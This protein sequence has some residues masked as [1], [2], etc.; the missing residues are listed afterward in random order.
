MALSYKHD[1]AYKLLLRFQHMPEAIQGFIMLS[2]ADVF[3]TDVN[4]HQLIVGTAVK[5]LLR[6]SVFNFSHNPYDDIFDGLCALSASSSPV[7]VRHELTST[8]DKII[9][10]FKLSRL[11]GF[12]TNIYASRMAHNLTLSAKVVYPS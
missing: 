4:R 8:D 11:G 7:I 10:A 6:G 2:N 9:D 5:D 3:I 12:S 1:E